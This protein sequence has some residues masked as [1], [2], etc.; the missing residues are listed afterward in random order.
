MRNRLSDGTTGAT[1]PISEMRPEPRRWLM[2]IVLILRRG[3][4]TDRLFIVNVALPSIR[5]GLDAR[6]AMLQLVISGYA[7]TYAVMPVTDGRLRD[8]FGRTRI[9]HHRPR[10]VRRRLGHRGVGADSGLFVAGRILQGFMAAIL[11]HQRLVPWNWRAGQ[12]GP[13]AH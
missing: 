3:P 1:P 6:P 2:F 8:L 5:A 12:R 11:A 9:F 4:D 7:A 13:S 10:R